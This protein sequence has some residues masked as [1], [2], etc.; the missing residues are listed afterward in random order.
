MFEFL[1]ERKGSENGLSADHSIIELAAKRLRGTEST[2][3]LQYLDIQFLLPAY[4]MCERFFRIAGHVM[5]NC[6]KEIPPSNFGTQLLFYINREFCN[7]DEVK[8]GFKE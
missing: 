7:N 6:W 3:S 1:L 5:T 2:D 8:S 4:S